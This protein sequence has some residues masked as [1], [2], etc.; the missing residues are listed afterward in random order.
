M[1]VV[2]LQYRRQIWWHHNQEQ[3]HYDEH[4]EAASE[5]EVDL[6]IGMESSNTSSLEAEGIVT[7][8][9]G[10]SKEC[11]PKETPLELGQSTVPMDDPGVSVVLVHQ[12]KRTPR[13]GE[14]PD[15]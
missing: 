2:E 8:E 10:I 3:L 9:I 7:L 15:L 5:Q 14:R 4:C 1:W 6:P 11:H 13:P 12:S